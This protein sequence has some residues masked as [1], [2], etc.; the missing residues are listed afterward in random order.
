MHE[1]YE[2][3]LKEV[4][5][6]YAFTSRDLIKLTSKEDTRCGTTSKCICTSRGR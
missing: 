5:I 3:K 2:E 6:T 1:K 4:D